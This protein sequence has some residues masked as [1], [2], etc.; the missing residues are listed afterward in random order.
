VMKGGAERTA[1]PEPASKL[2][3]QERK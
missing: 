1:P 2:V 3:G